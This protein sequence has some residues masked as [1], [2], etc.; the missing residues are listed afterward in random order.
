MTHS[1]VLPVTAAAADSPVDTRQAIELAEGVTVHLPVAGPVPRALAYSIDLLIRIGIYYFMAIGFAVVSVALEEAAFGLFLLGMFLLEWFYNV[2]FEMGRH[3]ATP[4]QRMFGLRVVSETGAAPTLPQSLLRNLLR[5]ADF[6]PFGYGLGVVVALSTRRFQRLGDLAAR[7]LVIHQEKADGQSQRRAL[8]PLSIPLPPPPAEPPPIPLTPEESRAILQFE[9]RL[10]TWTAER[11]AEIAGHAVAAA[12]R[13]S[14]PVRQL[15][16]I[17]RWLHEPAAAAIAGAHEE[18][19]QLLDTWVS[20]L[21]RPKK[22]KR[23]GKETTP[24]LLPWAGLPAVFRQV[25]ADLALARQRCQSPVLIER[26][27][28]LCLR[29]CQHLYGGRAAL[30]T[31]IA[32]FLTTGFPKAV[33]SEWRLVAWCHAFF[34]LPFFALLIWGDRDPRWFEAVLGPQGMQSMHEMYD[35]KDRVASARDSIG[36]NFAMFGMYVWNNVGIAFRTFAGGILAGVGALFITAY[37]GIAIGAAAGYVTRAADPVAFWTFVSGHAAFELTGIVLSAAAGL[38]LGLALIAPG[39]Q[40]RPK[41]LA[42][43]ADRAFPILSGAALLIVAAAFIE[44]FWSPLPFPPGL[45][46]AVGG[47]MW[48]LLA[49]YL[50]LAGRANRPA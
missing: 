1:N 10:P 26:I 35:S 14:Q 39:A 25:C 4:G 34:W 33:R 18:R 28:A 15:R 23:S 11:Q 48:L 29:T 17:A 44:G 42:M 22:K 8:A 21:E 45:K 46:Y 12:G 19:W 41:A 9:S 7:T 13:A 47:L 50:I 31:G 3:G 20:Q 37:N 16:A 43:A 6:L 32:G 5:T 36:E 27:N 2:F 38:R 40:S 24:P 49:A 30:R